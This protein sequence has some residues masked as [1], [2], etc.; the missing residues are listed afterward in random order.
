MQDLKELQAWIEAPFVL[1]I[2]PM[3]FFVF[4]G[5]LMLIAF[6]WAQIIKGLSSVREAV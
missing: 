5:L 3:Q 1:G 4:Y 2:S 6:M